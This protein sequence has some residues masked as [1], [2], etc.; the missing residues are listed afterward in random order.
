MLSLILKS[1][2]I[3]VAAS[4]FIG[5]AV[6]AIAVVVYLVTGIISSLVRTFKEV[7]AKQKANKFLKALNQ[8]SVTL[9]STKQKT[10]SR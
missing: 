2:L 10:D 1:C 7:Q 3:A 4:I 6:I 8:T 9:D 5:G